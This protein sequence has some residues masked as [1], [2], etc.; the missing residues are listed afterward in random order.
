MGKY[1]GIDIMLGSHLNFHA[2]QN[3]LTPRIGAFTAVVKEELDF[4]MEWDF[5]KGQEEWVMTDLNKTILR[6]ISRITLRT[7]VG[8]PLCRNEEL[9]SLNCLIVEEIFLTMVL[10]RFFPIF[11]HPLVGFLLPSCWRIRRIKK[12]I[13]AIVA[14]Y[15]RQRRR[16]Q[17]I[18]G[19]T[20]RKPEDVLQWMMDLA[21]E[22][23]GQP[24]NLATRYI[25]AILGS[26][27]SVSGVIK[28]TLY[29]ITAR[30]EYIPSLRKEIEQAMAEDKGWQKTTHA[31]L[32]K[33]DSFMKEVQRVNPPSAPYPSSV[34][35]KRVVMEPITLS[36]GLHL[37]RGTYICVVTT[38]H[39][40]DDVAAP[41][42]DNFDGYRYLKKAQ[43][44]NAGRLLFT[45]TDIDHIHFGHG[46]YA[47]PGR[48]FASMEIKAVLTRIL[49][50]YD[51]KFPEGQ[52][53]PRNLT[54]LELSYQDP[55]GRVEF[56][57]RAALLNR[58]LEEPGD[59]E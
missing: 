16:M 26:L 58:S 39:L 42:P 13:V 36:D 17:A 38:S 4:A 12:R 25:Y 52:G 32:Q 23:E 20:Y 48:H 5:P 14:P 40:Q 50:K 19:E 27:F 54:I 59:G 41:G 47:C 8:Y 45:S 53:R 56:R 55:G 44:P 24:E 2:V 31:K 6:V 3:K 21:N 29:E 10:M 34:G 22:K 1:T 7:F 43:D 9:L 30:P 49:T 11:L 46:R 37:P 33:L 57:E 51:M 28:D 35:F 18:E 15:I